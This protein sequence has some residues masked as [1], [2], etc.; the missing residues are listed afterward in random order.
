ME[1]L[2]CPDRMKRFGTNEERKLGGQPANPGLPGK[3]SV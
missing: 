3:T 2:A 1:V